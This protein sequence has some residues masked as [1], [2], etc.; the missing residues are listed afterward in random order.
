[1]KQK[2]LTVIKNTSS[3]M[4]GHFLDGPDEDEAY[5]LRHNISSTIFLKTIR[6]QSGN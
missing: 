2:K 3:D 1:M 4:C 5:I 6:L